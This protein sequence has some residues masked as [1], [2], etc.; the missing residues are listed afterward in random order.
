MGDSKIEDLYHSACFY[1]VLGR[2]S[3]GK[4]PSE[5]HFEA[6]CD[7]CHGTQADV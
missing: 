2:I 4:H 3:G 6:V 1:T 5:H 7:L